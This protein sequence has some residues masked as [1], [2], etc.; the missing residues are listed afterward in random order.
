MLEISWPAYV[1][2]S[3]QAA[4]KRTSDSKVKLQPELDIP[5]E[6]D[7]A[8][9]RRDAAE[10]GA[11]EI[12]RRRIEDDDVRHIEGFEPE[13]ESPPVAERD[14]LEQRSIQRRLPRPPNVVESIRRRALS[15]RRALAP[16]RR[17][18]GEAFLKIPG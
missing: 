10:V 12:R 15:E 6:I 17:F 18:A 1:S 13:L 11:L 16:D 8:P 9:R 4:G 2:A 14:V 7:A 3:V 5:R